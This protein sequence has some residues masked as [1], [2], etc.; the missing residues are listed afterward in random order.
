[1]EIDPKSI[2]KNTIQTN[3][4]IRS[5][6]HINKFKFHCPKCDKSF[7][8]KDNMI[9]HM[10]THNPMCPKCNKSFET[11]N[12]LNVHMKQHDDGDITFP[13]ECPF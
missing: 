12:E 6:P 7:H 1:M 2:G 4:H 13:N 10:K 8:K 11:K 5:Q 3:Y 9:Q